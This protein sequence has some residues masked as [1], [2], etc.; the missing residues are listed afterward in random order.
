[1]TDFLREIGKKLAERWLSLLA[2]P[3]LLYVA[4]AAV[5][6]VLGWAHALD[7]IRMSRQIDTWAS[8]PAVRS[9]GGIVL[10]SAAVVAGS[11]MAGLAAAAL[12]RLAEIIRHLPG[13]RPPA[14]WLADRRRSRSQAAKRA[15]DSAETATEIR[16]AIRGA[17]R[18][19]RIE[20]DRPTWTADR[21]HACR[22]RI[23]RAYGLDLDVIWP[24]LWLILPDSARAEINAARDGYAA[25]ARLYG[26]SLLYLMLAVW[27]WP[28]A[29]I[30]LAIATTAQLTTRS[31]TVL[32]TDLIEAA[33][34]VYAPVLAA[35]LDPAAAPAALTPEQG[36][37]L[38]ALL[39][40]SR[41]DPD[42]PLAD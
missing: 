28:A 4:V 38:T 14:R 17:D 9:T 18:L 26:W 2:L 13:R 21:L 33:V 6:H 8:S 37:S 42:S 12:G 20:A 41:W 3:G 23:E 22:V 15:A 5:A 35:H 30:A 36:R 29:V 10:I 39:R 16:A 32:L 11:V 1:M 40:R 27:W 25:S 24:R 7:P 34:D 19:S 31:A